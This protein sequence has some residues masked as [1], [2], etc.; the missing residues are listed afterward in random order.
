MNRIILL[1]TSGLLPTLGGVPTGGFQAVTCEGSYAHHLQ[2][3]CRDDQD[4]IFWSFT[5]K[6]VKTD[7]AG[8]VLEQ[9]DV[10]NH[11]GDLCFHQGKVYVAL[12]LGK[13]NDP[14]G[15]ADS[16]VYI[17]N[18]GDLSLVARHRTPEVFHGAGGIAFHDGKFLIVGG[19]PDDVNE[20]YVYEYDDNFQFLRK[21]SLDGGHT[22]LGIQTVAFADGHWWFGCYGRPKSDSVAASSPILLKAD[23]TLK[24]VRRFEFDCS[25]GIVPIGNHAFLVGRGGPTRD[26]GQMGR[27]VMVVGDEELGLKLVEKA[28]EKSR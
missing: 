1:L 20:N 5:T 22:H 4:S 19:L 21:H 8:K 13:F 27:L 23:A 6:L 2:G 25:L 11:H 3:V 10:A 28:G 17:Y 26:K 12:N 14:K 7:R 24:T 9:V 15:N 18:A 16:W